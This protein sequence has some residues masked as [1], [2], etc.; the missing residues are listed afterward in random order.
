MV[1][2]KI[3]E[4]CKWTDSQMNEMMNCFSTKAQEIVR[5]TSHKINLI[6]IHKKKKFPKSTYYSIKGET[7]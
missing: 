5:I 1:S 4:S 2:H 7:S 3:Y 6:L